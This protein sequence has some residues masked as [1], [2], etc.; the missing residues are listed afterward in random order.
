MNDK[1]E[2]VKGDEELKKDIPTSLESPKVPFPQRL[3]KAQDAQQFVKFLEIFKILQV[4][5]P[6]TKAFS[7]MSL[8]AKYF[9][10]IIT[11]KES[12]K[13]TKW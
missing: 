7:Q 8:Y 5:I 11:I 1:E 3:R 9:K 2:E 6:F 4:N 10:D 12:G 13:R